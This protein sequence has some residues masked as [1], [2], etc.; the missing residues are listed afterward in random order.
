MSTTSDA[1][2]IQF[3]NAVINV[4]NNAT[5]P[6]TERAEIVNAAARYVAALQ[7]ESDP[8][9]SLAEGFV[10]DPSGILNGINALVASVG[11]LVEDSRDMRANNSALRSNPTNE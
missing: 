3:T 8:F 5:I 2:V 9:A 11:M 10:K 4:M 6:A 1:T 7:P